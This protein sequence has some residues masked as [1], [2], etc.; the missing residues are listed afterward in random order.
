VSFFSD[1]F[2][3]VILRWLR[4]TILK[5]FYSSSKRFIL[6]F[7]FNFSLQFKNGNRFELFVFQWGKFSFLDTFLRINY[8]NELKISNPFIILFLSFLLILLLLK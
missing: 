7:F 2:F 1:I 6:W 5:G 3:E 8:L 4:A